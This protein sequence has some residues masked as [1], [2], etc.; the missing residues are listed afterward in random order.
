[1]E[2]RLH[3]SEANREAR[4]AHPIVPPLSLR[5]P[6]LTIR[7]FSPVPIRADDDQPGHAPT[8][9]GPRTRR[10]SV[11][12]SAS[13]HRPTAVLA[14]VIPRCPSFR[15]EGLI[16]VVPCDFAVDDGGD[17]PARKEGHG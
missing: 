14:D 8:R 13:S 2:P 9:R 7:T 10:P 11:I 6:A 4:I 17:I 15:R 3:C 5:G 12:S 16:H 1:M